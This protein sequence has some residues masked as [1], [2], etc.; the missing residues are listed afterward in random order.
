M[1]LGEEQEFTDRIDGVHN[2][3]SIDSSYVQYSSICD[4]DS[5][6]SVEGIHSTD[7]MN[8]KTFSQPRLQDLQRADDDRDEPGGQLP[9][10]GLRTEWSRRDLL[11]L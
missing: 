9:R 3:Y 1:L 2:I 7:S 8:R 11:N 4:I 6:D 5:T 10:Q